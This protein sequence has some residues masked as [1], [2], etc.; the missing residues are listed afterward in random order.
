MNEIVKS[1]RQIDKFALKMQTKLGPAKYE[2]YRMS[3]V[4][5]QLKT[6]FFVIFANQDEPESFLF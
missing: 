3:W 1:H 2:S 4:R 5:A 6:S